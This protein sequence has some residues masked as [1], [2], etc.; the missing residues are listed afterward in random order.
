[1]GAIGIGGLILAVV[2]TLS[3]VTFLGGESGLFLLYTL[4]FGV[5]IGLPA[6]VL[7]IVVAVIGISRSWRTSIVRRVLAAI[8]IVSM[9]LTTIYIVGLV[10]AWEDPWLDL[11]PVIGFLGF[12][13]FIVTG[14]TGLSKR[15]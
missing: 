9:L 4:P 7:T 11:T 13:M 2:V 10:N 1:M 8:S 3:P 6:L 12:I 5:L 14:F 15:A